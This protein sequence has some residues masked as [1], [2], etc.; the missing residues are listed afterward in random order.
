MRLLHLASLVGWCKLTIRQGAGQG[1]N[2]LTQ[3]QDEIHEVRLAQIVYS[4]ISVAFAL[5]MG[6]FGLKGGAS[7]VGRGVEE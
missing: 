3:G 7:L 4:L 1:S 2:M 5:A 6:E